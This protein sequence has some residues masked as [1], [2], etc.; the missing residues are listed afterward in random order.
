MTTKTSS[1][2]IGPGTR[3]NSV[4]A[5]SNPTWEITRPRGRGVWEAKITD[6]DYAGTVK[7]FT[8]AE[9]KHAVGM[10]SAF[11]Q[12]DNENDAFYA[13]LK[14]GQ[15]VHYHNSF[16]QFVRCEVVMGTTVHDKTMHK[17]LKPIALVGDWKSYD[18]PRR[19][20]NGEVDLG[21]QA[22]KI[23]KGDC[24]EPN[25]GCIY[26]SGERSGSHF[27]TDPSKL[28]ALDL[29]VPELTADAEA[30]AKLWKAVEAARAVL[31]NHKVTD[32]KAR[33]TAAL[34]TIQAGL[35]S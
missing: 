8:T 25:Y 34:A 10:A 16:G 14:L 24:F 29:S 6:H 17:C 7:V 33:L 20:P 31:E 3:F 32:P 1:P 5:D 26:E 22:E 23:A 18:L 28:P 11:A 2:K 21:Y 9:V 35:T 19:L 13:S 12:M 27:D 15:I 30:T 4:Y